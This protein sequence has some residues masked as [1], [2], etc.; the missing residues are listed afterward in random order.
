MEKPKIVVIVGPTASG[1]TALS[2]ELAKEFAGEVISA[3]SRQVYKGLDIGTEKV[4]ETEMEGVVHHLIDVTKPTTVYTAVD[5][6]RDTAAAITEITG[7]EKLPI[8]AGG[9]FFYIDT[10]LG[11]VVAPKV[12]PQPKL[13]TELETKSTEVLYL[14]LQ[15]LD[16]VR[17]ITIDPHNQR[18]LV[19]AIEVAT[20]LGKVPA[21]ATTPCPYDVLMLGIVT[22]RDALR[23]RIRTRAQEALTK[24]L[25]EETQSLLKSGITRARLSEIGLE[26]RII[27]EYING[28]LDEAALI[29][30]LEE[31]NWQ[32]AK[33]Q[34]LWLKR[35]ESIVWVDRTDVPSVKDLVSDFLST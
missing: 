8:I 16:P 29:Q 23:T 15:E 27:M 21:P 12:K 35:D 26:Y 34:L 20:V 24:G 6:A 10:L 18:R 11:R 5:F 33:R 14:K 3:D 17:A 7:R 30:K 2:I 1:K 4:T 32:Y 28:D 22:N 13:R 9:T 25:V 31:K 19:R